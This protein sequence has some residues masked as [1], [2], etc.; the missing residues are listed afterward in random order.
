M[1]KPIIPQKYCSR[2]YNVRRV[3]K[4]KRK[5]RDK[6]EIESEKKTTITT[7]N[8]SLIFFPFLSFFTHSSTNTKPL[9]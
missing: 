4:R 8:F 7:T 3:K 1:K 5:T 6:N 2:L 9:T